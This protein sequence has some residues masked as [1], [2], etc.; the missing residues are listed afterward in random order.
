MFSRSLYLHAK[1]NPVAKV[2]YEELRWE[3]NDS[4]ETTYKA[5]PQVTKV[6]ETEIWWSMPISTL[7]KIPDMII[8][9]SDTNSDDLWQG[10][11]N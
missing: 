2:V 8:W 3:L 11:P 5:T 9:H 10:S 4:E 7:N 1:H 6:K